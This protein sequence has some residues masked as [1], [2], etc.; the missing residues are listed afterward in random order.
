MIEVTYIM[1]LFYFYLFFLG[2]SENV[3][4]FVDQ[5][6]EIVC[7]HPRGHIEVYEREASRGVPYRYRSAMWV[8]EGK[9]LRD[10]KRVEVVM[11]N[12]AIERE[13]R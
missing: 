5:K 6:N 4:Q 9:R 2:C 11:N 7:R 3:S 10:G 13:V 1:K 8:F 12:C